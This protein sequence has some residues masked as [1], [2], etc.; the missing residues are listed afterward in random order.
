MSGTAGGTCSAVWARARRTRARGTPQRTYTPRARLAPRH[1]R[2]LPVLPRARGRDPTGGRSARVRGVPTHP[3]G[4]CAPFPNLFPIVGPDAAPGATGAHEVVVLCTRSRPRLRCAHRCRG[5]RGDDRAPQGP[6]PRRG[7][8]PRTSR[9]WS[10][11]A[12]ATGRVDRAPPRRAAR[13]GSRATGGRRRRSPVRTHRRRHR[14]PRRRRRAR[15]HR[16]RRRAG[17]T[18]T[19]LVPLGI[20]VAVGRADRGTRRGSTLR[21][22]DR[23]AARRGGRARCVACSMRSAPT[24][25]P[26]RAATVSRTIHC[27]EN[28]QRLCQGLSQAVEDAHGYRRRAYV[29]AATT[30]SQWQ[31]C[32][33]DPRQLRLRFI[34]AI[35]CAPERRKLD[36]GPTASSGSKDLIRLVGQSLGACLLE[37][38]LP[39][40]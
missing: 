18:R 12:G 25:V 28:G 11:R 19:R 33:H 4:G 37:Q 26:D 23:R 40:F 31:R 7:R 34:R 30:G 27:D 8:A 29:L 16:R 2:S 9:C 14:R 3:G 15:P 5:G 17:R 39:L 38:S 35:V 36:A 6:S 13:A 10:T 1:R 22:C 32:C 21:R 24:S 20:A